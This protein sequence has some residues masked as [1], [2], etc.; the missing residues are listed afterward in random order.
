MRWQIL[1]IHFENAVLIEK[2]V[3]HS[4]RCTKSLEGSPVIVAGGKMPY[5]ARIQSLYK[6]KY[7]L[8]PPKGIFLMEHLNFPNSE[9][10]NV[11][12]A[13]AGA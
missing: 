7:P 3:F 12:A 11:K 10:E 9:C 2:D 6:A 1:I 4:E 13:G 5:G 8:E